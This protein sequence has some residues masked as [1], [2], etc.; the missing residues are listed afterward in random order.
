MNKIIKIAGLILVPTVVLVAGY[1]VYKKFIKK[2]PLFPG[3][4]KRENDAT[5]A[6]IKKQE[7]GVPLTAEEIQVVKASATKATAGRGGSNTATPDILSKVVTPSNTP[8]SCTT[9]DYA[10]GTVYVLYKKRAIG[11]DTFKQYDRM[12]DGCTNQFKKYQ[13]VGFADLSSQQQKSK[14]IISASSII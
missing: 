4:A 1:I 6:L 8:P 9:P 3:A 14:E 11:Q 12:N 7:S 2:E 10:T 5:L 13:Y